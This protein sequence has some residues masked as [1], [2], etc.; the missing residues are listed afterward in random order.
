MSLAPSTDPLERLSALVRAQRGALVA[1]ARREGLSPEDALECVQ[2]ALCD[3][4]GAEDTREDE[5]HVVAS[6]K[7]MVRNRAR[8]VRR[9]HRVSRP[10][11]ALENSSEL[12]ASGALHEE[13][14]V[15]AEEV[16]RLRRC[17]ASLCDVQ[18]SVVLLRLLEERSGEDVALAL[19]LT[20][21]HV[22]VLVYRAKGALRVCMRHGADATRPAG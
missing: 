15:H 7:T 4:L 16:V 11:V 3:F 21:S 17:V 6:V 8:N 20:R 9:L 2:D 13:L 12:P 1:V 22:D 14:L 19:G 5:A 18:R 10:H